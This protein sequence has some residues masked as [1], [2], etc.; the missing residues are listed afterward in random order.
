MNLDW[1]RL[2]AVVIESDDWGLCAWSPDELA[3]RVLTDL[4]AF[5]TESGRRYAGSTLESAED[6]RLLA[7]SLLEFR[8]GDGFPP[9]WQAN[10]VVASPDYARL[11]PPLFEVESL[12][13]ID[14]PGTPTRWHRPGLWDRVGRACAAGLWWPELHGLHHIPEQAWLKALRRGVPDARRA[15]EQQSPV[16]QAVDASGEYDPSEPRDVRERNVALA[17]EKFT[18]LF[19]RP[20]HSLC[21]PDYRWNED[22]EEDALRL[23]VTTLQGRAEQ[24]GRR[25]PRL[26]RLLLR[27][28]WPVPPGRLFELPPRTAFEPHVVPGAAARLIESMMRRAREAWNRGQ[29]A[30]LSSH[31]ANYAHLEPTRAASSRAALRDLLKRLVDVGA[32]FLVDAEVR[33]LQE[34]SWSVRL[35]GDRGALVRYYGVPHA[36]VRFPAPAGVQ[37]VSIRE[38]RGPGA[39]EAWLEGGDVVAELN[40]GEYLL[41]WGRS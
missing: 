17:V 23:G 36:A 39:S 35:V 32:V 16:C 28:R 4:P 33:D 15:H 3:F 41:E 22:L 11:V 30:I 26:R 34:R 21:P 12:P 29:P 1:R 40:V 19:G 10:T 37:Q 38:E 2:K 7:E 8:G 24:M 25:F 18:T 6:V 14:L 27:Y 31:R 20:P 9:V 5:R 13:L